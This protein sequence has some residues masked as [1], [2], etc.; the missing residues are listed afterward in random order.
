MNH[1]HYILAPRVNRNFHGDSFIPRAAA[2]WNSLPLECFPKK[3]DHD[4]FKK[5]VNVY[6]SHL[7]YKD[8]VSAVGSP[9]VSK[10]KKDSEL[11]DHIALTARLKIM[12]LN[13]E[14]ISTSKCDYLAKLLEKHNVDILLLQETHLNDKAPPSRSQIDGYSVINKQN[15]AQYGLITYA[16]APDQVTDLGGSTEENGTQRSTIKIGDTEITNVYKP[17]KIKW[18]NPPKQNVQHPSII[19]G[20]F[21]SHHND[22]GY[23]ENDA[24]GLEVN[25]W[26]NQS[27]LFLLHNPKDKGTFRPARRDGNKS[28]HLTL[29]SHQKTRIKTLYQQQKKC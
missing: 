26:A 23:K 21:N 27:D 29:P 1:P 10:N 13:V 16:R 17:P 14:G 22:W 24:S 2:Q 19:A 11:Q 8:R 25:E 15:H 18:T 20:D 5:R 12:T 6:L 9:T 3:C 28:T 4:A 7:L